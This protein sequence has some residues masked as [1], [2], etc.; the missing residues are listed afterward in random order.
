MLACAA[1]AL[2]GE[3]RGRVLGQNGDG[4]PQV[5]V[6]VRELPPGSRPPLAAQAPAEAIMDQVDKEFVPHVLP[7]KI[8][9]EVQFPNHD[10]IHHHVYSFSRTKTFELPLYRDEMPAPVRFDKAG[11]VKIGCNIHD[12][13]L[14][15]IL[16]LPTAYYATTD[17]A[18]EF[19]L[20][21]LPPGN[22]SLAHW[23][24]LSRTE[25]EATLRTVQVN[26]KTADLTFVLPLKPARARSPIHGI[27]GDR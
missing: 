10:Q 21:G 20:P 7:V 27:R 9:T 19:I 2:A 8:G 14:G 5:V 17:E 12:W 1:P 24:E 6:F 13:M 15:V 11:A 3:I 26:D 23:H 25:V 4:I 22:Y 16:I 18:G